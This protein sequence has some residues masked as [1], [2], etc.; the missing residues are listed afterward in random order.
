MEISNEYIYI[1][2]F[3]TD[4]SKGKVTELVN[5][6]PQ[7]KELFDKSNKVFIDHCTLLHRSQEKENQ[8]ILERL[9]ILECNTT[10]PI[11]AT[12]VG[13]LNGRA[14]AIKVTLDKNI[15]CANTMPHITI[16]TFG[17][18]KPFDSNKITG[19]KKLDKA[20]YLEGYLKTI[21]K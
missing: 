19:W 20:L 8:S 17:N 15:H 10:F 12:H 11:V 6:I 21:E 5:S 2:L 4:K 18:G 13:F 3:L 14:M 16:C 1:G 9:R 7:Y